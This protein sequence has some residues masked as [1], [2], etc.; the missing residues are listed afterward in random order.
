MG[1]N[2]FSKDFPFKQ[3]EKV[4]TGN[5]PKIDVSQKEQS[6]E[7]LT[8]QNSNVENND[9]PEGHLSDI[10]DLLSFDALELCEVETLKPNV[11][12]V[13]VFNLVSSCKE[14]L[15][16]KII[17]VNE[18][19]D[20]DEK[21]ENRVGRKIYGYIYFKNEN[22]QETN[23][24][25]LHIIDP[26]ADVSLVSLCRLRE[27]FSEKFLEENL[28]SPNYKNISCFNNSIMK[29]ESQ[30]R[31][32]CGF[33]ENN[34]GPQVEIDF[35]VI[36]NEEMF[37]D[38]L[39]G[40]DFLRKY[41]A[42]V[43]YPKKGGVTLPSVRLSLPYPFELPVCYLR[44]HELNIKWLDIDIDGKH[45]IQFQS[46]LP[47]FNNFKDN[48]EI[49]ASLADNSNTD[50]MMLPSK[51][52]AKEGLFICITNLSK[53]RF[54]GKIRCKIEKI[55]KDYEFIYND[56]PY[57]QGTFINEV[58][59]I[60]D[61]E[62]EDYQIDIND[63]N[64]LHDKNSSNKSL[65]DY[66]PETQLTRELNDI[67]INKVSDVI[68]EPEVDREKNIFHKKDYGFSIPNKRLLEQVIVTD[69][70]PKKIRPYVR[71]LFLKR[72]PKIVSTDPYDVGNISRFLGQFKIR[73][74]PGCKLPSHQKLYYC[75]GE[76]REQLSTILSF[77]CKRK[78]IEPVPQT[79]GEEGDNSTSCWASPCY[80]V[81]KKGNES[82]YRLILDFSYI[83][84]L[85]ERPPAVLNR[86]DLMLNSLR[87]ATYFTCVDFSNAYFSLSIDEESKPL[88]RF[89]SPL[90]VYQFLKLPQGASCSASA[91]A[92]YAD[93]MVHHVPKL[94]K[95]G[96]FIY[97][98]DGTLELQRDEIPLT[99]AYMDDLIIA[100][101]SIGTYDEDL[102]HHFKQVIKVMDRVNLHS[103]KISYEKSLFAKTKIFW[104]G[105]SIQNQKLFPDPS[106]IT[107]LVQFPV[108]TCTRDV[109]SFLGLFQTLKTM[110]P[111]EFSRL[112]NVLTPLTSGKQVFKMSEEQL[113]AFMQLKYKLTV[114]PLF[115]NLI[116]PTATK[117]LWVDAAASRG[118][119]YGGI[120]TQIVARQPLK[121]YVPDHL[122][123]E[124][125]SHQ[126]LYSEKLPYKPC[127]FLYLNGKA[128]SIHELASK[129]FKIPNI[130]WNDLSLLGFNEDNYNDSLFISLQT[131]AYM[132][133]IKIMSI[134]ELKSKVIEGLK[135]IYAIQILTEQ[136]SN[137]NIAYK[138]F[139]NNF[140]YKSNQPLDSQLV[141]LQTIAPI[142]RKKF[143]II[144]T[145][146]LLN[147]DNIITYGAQYSGNI[148]VVSLQEINGK[149][150]FSPFYQDKKEAIDLAQFKNKIQLIGFYSQKCGPTDA[151]LSIYERELLALLKSLAH[152]STLIGSSK[153]TVLTDSHSLYLCFNKQLQNQSM[154]LTRWILK[155]SFH[156]PHLKLQFVPGK[157]NIAD[158]L[159]K[160]HVAPPPLPNFNIKT[161]KV[162]KDIDKYL[163]YNKPYSLADFEKF[164]EAHQNLIE[165]DDEKDKLVTVNNINNILDNVEESLLPAKIL[166]SRLQYEQIQTQQQ[167]YFKDKLDKCVTALDFQIEEKEVKYKIFNGLLYIQQPKDNFRLMV[168]PNLVSMLIFLTHLNGCH[169]GLAKMQSML[170]TY[171]FENLA[172]TIIKHLKI[173]F[174]CFLNNHPKR[175]Y[176]M[177]AMP[178][179]NYPG[180]VIHLDFAES[181]GLSPGQKFNHLLVA[182]DSLSSYC[183][184]FPTRTKSS[185][186]IIDILS[187]NLVAHYN[188]VSFISD[189]ASCFQSAP[190]YRFCHIYN[191][192]KI[193]IS[194]FHPTANSIVERK[195]GVL[196]QA[197]RREN[198]KLA[199]F[200]WPEFIGIVLKQL[201]STKN[202][203]YDLSPLELLHGAS[204]HSENP[205]DLKLH[206]SL[207]I[208]FNPHINLQHNNELRKNLIKRAQEIIAVDKATRQEK[209]NRTRINAEFAIND[210]VF[211]KN[212]DRVV[213]TTQPLKSFWHTE[214]LIVRN[215]YKSSLLLYRPTTAHFHLYFKGD[216][217]KFHKLDK[218]IILPN[219]LRNIVMK[220]PS[221]WDV[222][223]YKT[224]N[225]LSDFQFPSEAIQ[226][227]SDEEVLKDSEDILTNNTEKQLIDKHLYDPVKYHVDDELYLENDLEPDNV[228]KELSVNKNTE[229]PDTAPIPVKEVETKESKLKKEVETKNIVSESK[230]LKDNVPIRKSK[231]LA[232]K[233]QKNN[234][235]IDNLDEE[236][237]DIIE[238]KTVSFQ[239][240]NIV[241]PS[242]DPSSHNNES[243]SVP[244]EQPTK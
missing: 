202:P 18:E 81:S 105:W 54:I 192:K 242:V 198:V 87:S 21:R 135:G 26:G 92:N 68:N 7:Q 112:A 147:E 65:E 113:D 208:N 134:D 224:L 28:K 31:L 188:I 218:T 161:C 35:L 16:N 62:K 214:P 223:D 125:E 233:A 217:K 24:K 38:F 50:L 209:I 53:S 12:G 132:Y 127:N 153:I 69:H 211:A 14:P 175:A 194:A 210:I 70:L 149:I 11:C 176:K 40:D 199:Q 52:I 190:F 117:L 182:T 128:K 189:G 141:M 162:S 200:S 236:D 102:D 241:P 96:N 67:D 116:E 97:K 85:L 60:D 232:V 32:L 118:S 197:L 47:F 79:S 169:A 166:K 61:Q 142:I 41:E 4:L 230:N 108:P 191:I 20:I 159:T 33:E 160:F 120:L 164:V 187:I 144:N 3:K 172:T 150:I 25:G 77:L 179:A 131:I 111:L 206:N 213:G 240:Q 156:W 171:W 15:I 244:A 78:I 167:R 59:V 74:K 36:N 186:E 72:F 1:K 8:V 165:V 73:L 204:P 129:P 151:R 119:S 183:W 99:F 103:G 219:E 57:E 181:I 168:P 174:P 226:L 56:G 106:R 239:D 22:L 6:F 51:S 139:I 222:L 101:E 238:E 123:L 88:T 115:S 58:V 155:L 133:K 37:C 114:R 104:L 163:D 148:F 93:L 216:V 34:Q 220:L 107:K 94:D 178:L 90:G 229:I 185:Q 29:V 100:S 43:S 44:K 49:I 170:R 205:F 201:N 231:R 75:S 5:P 64:V 82:S 243:T 138:G 55:T 154:K 126:I 45:S 71:D 91:F 212:R 140:K 9:T 215:V 48:D 143:I 122:N 42:S 84:P 136:F 10:S 66:I 19:S 2:R 27:V 89:L 157:S 237:E 203:K 80:L 234:K 235:N 98:T 221:T 227:R 225:S 180:Q 109:R 95:N 145:T 46:K 207:P 152:F 137:D 130:H 23:Q 86:I 177:G 124:I 17:A 13:T 146:N 193:Q 195:I 158:I 39:L 76:I 196:K 30:I 184:A 83:N 110:V 228:D 63:V 173:C 121:P